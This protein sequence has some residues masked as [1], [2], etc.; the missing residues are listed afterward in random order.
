MRAQRDLVYARASTP[1]PAQPPARHLEP[2]FWNPS[3]KIVEEFQNWDTFGMMQQLGAVPAL[4]Q[5]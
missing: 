3:G 2:A 4:A 1:K 5:V